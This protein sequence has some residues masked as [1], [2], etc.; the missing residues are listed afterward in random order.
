MKVVVEANLTAPEK[1]MI[2]EAKN[3]VEDPGINYIVVRQ[4]KAVLIFCTWSGVGGKGQ[5][6]LDPFRHHPYCVNENRIFP[7]G[8]RS[9]LSRA[10]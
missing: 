5:R 8:V 3:R 6:Y 7:F 4:F 9:R 2:N 1:G 10:T